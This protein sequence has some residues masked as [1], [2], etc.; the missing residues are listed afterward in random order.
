MASGG[1]IEDCFRRSNSIIVEQRTK[2]CVK[3]Q[4]G[5]VPKQRVLCMGAAFAT[6]CETKGFLGVLTH[7]MSFVFST[8]DIPPC[9]AHQCASGAKRQSVSLTYTP[10]LGHRRRERP[11]KSFAQKACVSQGIPPPAQLCGRSVCIG[12]KQTTSPQPP[13]RIHAFFE[14][15]GL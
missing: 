2:K 11:I 7:G 4:C 9:R 1:W 15:S 8:A 12:Q 10:R 3:Q 13:T 5:R 14:S 6:R